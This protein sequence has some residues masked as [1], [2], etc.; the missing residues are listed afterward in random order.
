[1]KISKKEFDK[2]LEKVRV[3]SRKN[4]KKAKE[5]L[6]DLIDNAENAVIVQTDNGSAF[7]GNKYDTCQLLCNMFKHLIEEGAFTKDEINELLNHVDSSLTNDDKLERL[8]ELL[9]K[10]IK[11]QE[12][13]NKK[14]EN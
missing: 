14:E 2:E 9:D 3:E 13:Q 8:G 11:L 5:K 10:A 12:L 7:I 6:K 1:M 4:V